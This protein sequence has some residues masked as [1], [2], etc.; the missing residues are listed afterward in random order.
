MLP[1]LQEPWA[2]L[3]CFLLAS[4]MHFDVHCCTPSCADW[5]HLKKIYFSDVT[6]A[7][8]LINTALENPVFLLVSLAQTL[9]F[10]T[11]LM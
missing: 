8:S 2:Y 3:E 4:R 5:P 6:F 9:F 11:G 7:H 1:T 10:E